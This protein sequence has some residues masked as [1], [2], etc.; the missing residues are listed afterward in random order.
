MNFRD[1]YLDLVE[2]VLTGRAFCD[3]AMDPW[4]PPGYN[5]K[6]RMFGQDWP[7]LALT[8]TGSIRM[9]TLRKM[10]QTVVEENIPGDLVET[11]VW[12]GG[13]CIYMKLILDAFGDTKRNVWVC[14]SFQG[15][16]PPNPVFTED[17][18]DPH[19]TYRPLAVS[20]HEVMENFKRFGA[21]DDRVVFLEGWFKDTLPAAPIDRIS[22][23]RLDGDMYE[24]TI[25][26]LESL[27]HRIVP[28]GFVIID[29]YFMAPCAKAVEDFRE[30]YGIHQP[31][32][33]IDGMG[34][35]WHVAP[36]F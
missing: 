10:V 14:D 17:A 12:R 25:D 24:S 31:I 11:G 30:K 27:Y 18:G 35:W 4:S 5:E 34:S 22:I 33:P 1:K 26:A 2:D 3:P 15:L 36:P 7:S 29:D 28:G 16:P 9:R 8:M 21:L 13:S 6:R 32:F 20:R 23:L 19:H